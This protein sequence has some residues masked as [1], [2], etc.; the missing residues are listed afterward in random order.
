MQLH[1]MQALKAQKHQQ[2]LQV[3]SKTKDSKNSRTG[4]QSKN[5]KQSLDGVPS[6]ELMEGPDIMEDLQREWDA[7]T[8]EIDA[9][10]MTIDE[11]LKKRKQAAVEEYQLRAGD[12]K[13]ERQERGLFGQPTADPLQKVHQ[14]ALE[15]R[16]AR[17]SQRRE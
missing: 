9:Q 6:I 14:K 4:T 13:Q 16:V 8:L 1:Q 10:K 5:S 12:N 2:I 15:M 7:L 17:R 3:Q 11:L